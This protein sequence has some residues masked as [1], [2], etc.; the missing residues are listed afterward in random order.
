ML[1]SCEALLQSAEMTHGTG[2]S[3]ALLVAAQM[4]SWDVFTLVVQTSVTIADA[5]IV[6]DTG[7][8]KEMQYDAGTAPASA[9][10]ARAP[11]KPRP[12][13][14]DIRGRGRGGSNR[15]GGRQAR[16]AGAAAASAAAAS[17]D[18]G[19]SDSDS[20]A[21]NTAAAADVSQAHMVGTG[22][23]KL[24]ETWVSQAS[25]KQRRGRAGR[26]R[27]GHTYWLARMHFIAVKMFWC[28][29]CKAV[30][31]VDARQMTLLSLHTRYKAGA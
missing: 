20:S 18:D 12:Q 8:M 5:T 2:L 7:K 27:C 19:G 11:Q 25:A 29:L 21:A 24:V 15:G 17:K 4:M 23:S 22:L 13:V 9:K 16:A 31:F 30:R 6:I 14:L 3:S 28:P 1:G 10:P 26:V